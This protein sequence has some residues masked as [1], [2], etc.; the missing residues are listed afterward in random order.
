MHKR[1]M[2][3][4]DTAIKVSV[5]GKKLF[6]MSKDLVWDSLQ[7]AGQCDVFISETREQKY[8][9]FLQPSFN[10]EVRAKARDPVHRREK[11]S[12]NSLF[13]KSSRLDKTVKELAKNDS[14]VGFVLLPFVVPLFFFS[15]L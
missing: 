12:S 14:K 15:D 3:E 10:K 8:S 7:L 11:F 6:D 4:L 2:V 1:A 13:E 5:D 9:E